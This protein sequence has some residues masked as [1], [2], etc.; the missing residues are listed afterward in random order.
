MEGGTLGDGDEETR[1]M[2]KT[3]KKK[4][5]AYCFTREQVETPVDTLIFGTS[6]RPIHLSPRLFHPCVRL[7]SAGLSST[8]ESVSN[9]AGLNG[10]YFG[11]LR[12]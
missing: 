8:T 2:A 4:T 6:R 9:V 7:S 11:L 12:D 10:S 3:P 5:H 1:K